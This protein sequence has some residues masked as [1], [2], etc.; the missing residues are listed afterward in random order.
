MFQF[1]NENANGCIMLLYSVILS[2]TVAR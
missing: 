2:R 1:E